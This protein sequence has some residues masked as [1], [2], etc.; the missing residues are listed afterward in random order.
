M[1]VRLF[2]TLVIHAS[3]VEAVEMCFNRTLR[4]CL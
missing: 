2:F 3:T 1:S 4:W